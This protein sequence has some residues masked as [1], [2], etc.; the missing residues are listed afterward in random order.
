MLN[1]VCNVPFLLPIGDTGGGI[2]GSGTWSTL[3]ERES[4]LLDL[5]AHM[6]WV[7]DKEG[8]KIS[9]CRGSTGQVKKEKID[10]ASEAFKLR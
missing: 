7:G 10:A 1:D 3:E 2:N 6:L 9:R 8:W 5:Q 4:Q